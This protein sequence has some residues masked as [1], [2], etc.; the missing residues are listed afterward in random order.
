[1]GS[2]QETDEMGEIVW[3][4]NLVWK[5][6]LWRLKLRTYHNEEYKDRAFEAIGQKLDLPKREEYILPWLANAKKPSIAPQSCYSAGQ[7]H[8]QSKKRDAITEG[9][10]TLTQVV[11]QQ[12]A[13]PSNNHGSTTDAGDSFG[14]FVACE[15]RKMKSPEKNSKKQKM[16][17][18]IFEKV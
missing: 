14:N 13:A 4:E 10:L 5:E 9:I 11:S 18:V 6:A 2:R 16:A 15:L 8:R 3:S 12:A 7:S 1:M 17:S